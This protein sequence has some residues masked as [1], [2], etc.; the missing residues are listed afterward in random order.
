MSLH[1]SLRF[2]DPAGFARRTIEAHEL[3]LSGGRTPD[4]ESHVVEAWRRSGEAGISPDQQQP[5]HVLTEA[6]LSAARSAT[7]LS[8]V[9]DD[10]V[11]SLADTSAAGR[12][13]VVVT[14]ADGVLLWRSGSRQ[15][16]R[17]A[18]AIAFAEGADWSEAGIGTNG[19]SLALDRG[20][21][22]HAM[23]GEHF[24]RAHYGWA[25][26]AAPIRDASGKI[27]GV[28]DV[29]LPAESATTEA[30]SLVRCGVRLAETLLA[31]EAR[32]S[33]APVP[34]TSIR[35]LGWRPEVTRADGTR[36]SLTS[37]R[38]ELL[39][40]LAS[41]EAWSARALAEALYDDAGAVSTVRGE[42]RRLRQLTGMEIGSQPYTLAEHER[43]CVDFL[44]TSDPADLLP[45]SDVPA[46]VDLR[47]TR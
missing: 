24:V 18:D 14:D 17:A 5:A 36:V 21:L 30:S 1:P 4:L 29:S 28:L 41:R 25:C 8:R 27:M 16:L 10:V 12:H 34:V 6:D 32:Q 39:A 26:I 40:L 23:A 3:V 46:I 9:A 33:P 45:D 44:N 37:R 31:R 20:E 42:V 19:I 11:A 7:P 35:L 2:S 22:S 38:A 13:L 43:A 15:S 47:Y